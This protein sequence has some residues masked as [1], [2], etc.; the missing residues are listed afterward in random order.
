MG[1]RVGMITGDNRRSAEANGRK[2]NLD[3]VIAEVLPHQKAE[4]VK[5]LQAEEVVA[6][7]GDG[8][9]DAP[10]LAQADLGIAIGSG[11]DIAIESGDIVLVRDDLRDVVAAIQLSKKTMSKIKQNIFWALIY[12]TIL[13]PAAAGLLYPIF[14]L[15]FRPEFAGMAMAMSSVSVVANSLLMKSYIPPVRKDK[16]GDSMEKVVLELSGLS[17]QHCI[18]RVK[19][20]LEEAG[21]KVEKVDLSEAV[22]LGNEGDVDKFVRAVETAGYGAKLKK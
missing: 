7:V 8:I 22:I 14:A 9:N 3:F 5:R 16:G 17:C 18:A 15:V 13:I 12:N 2:L 21:A 10:A 20:A 4:E 1:I 6:F 19:K 11:S